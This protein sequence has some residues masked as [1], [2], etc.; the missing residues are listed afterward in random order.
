MKKNVNLNE[1]NFNDLVAGYNELI[2]KSYEYL[3]AIHD[4]REQVVKEAVNAYKTAMTNL[5]FSEEEMKGL[6]S[7]FGAGSR[8][9]NQMLYNKGIVEN[10]QTPSF[11]S[12]ISGGNSP[13]LIEM[14]DGLSSAINKTS[15]EEDTIVYHGGHFNISSVVG[16]EITFKGFTSCS[17][18][19]SIAKDFSDNSGFIYKIALPKGSHGFCAN[20]KVKPYDRLSEH[21]EEHELLLDKGFKGK[22]ADIDYE[23]HIVTIIPT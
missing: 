4:K 5:G 15:L 10:N 8:E 6:T 23:N 9:L 18:Q 7:Y 3:K 19:E 21:G 22:I 11:L 2:A 12:I 13:S 14:N 17:F 20:A 16:D 1:M